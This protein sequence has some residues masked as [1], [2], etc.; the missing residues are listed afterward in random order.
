MQPGVFEGRGSIPQKGHTKNI[1]K[2]IQIGRNI[3][4]IFADFVTFKVIMIS[5][6]YKQK[7]GI[8]ILL[9]KRAGV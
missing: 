4:G 1:L 3:T 6:Y 8:F 2:R 7:K 9:M 5:R